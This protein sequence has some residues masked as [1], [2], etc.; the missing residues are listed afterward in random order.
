LIRKSK[1]NPSQAQSFLTELELFGLIEKLPGGKWR[2]K[3]I[4]Q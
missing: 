1:A 3:Q 4:A 2:K